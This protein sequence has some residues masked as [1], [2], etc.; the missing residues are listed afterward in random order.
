[1]DFAV[2]YLGVRFLFFIRQFFKHW[3]VDGT[4][5]FWRL[6]RRGFYLIDRTLALRITL[7]NFFRPLYGDYTFV[8]HI[9]GP[10]FRLGRTLVALL[11]YLVL[12]VCV[13]AVYLAWAAVIPL[14]LAYGF[15]LL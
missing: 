1:M 14:L 12:G 6:V 4:R 15:S 3:Y 5:A 10:L 8:G 11:V 9:L 13:L 7:R 2:S